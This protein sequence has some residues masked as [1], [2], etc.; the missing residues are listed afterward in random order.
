MLRDPVLGGVQDAVVV[1]VVAKDLVVFHQL[2]EPT[3]LSGP[4]ELR[5]VLDDECARP[6]LAHSPQEMLP[7]LIELSTTNVVPAATE[8]AE[9]LARRPADHDVGE[10]EV[11][12]VLDFTIVHETAEVTLEGPCRGSVVLDRV[13]WL[14]TE[15]GLLEPERQASGTREEIES[16]DGLGGLR[17]HLVSLPH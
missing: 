15:T 3:K 16:S 10:R 14:E 11:L 8:R 17:L 1:L 9:T 6:Y 7:K 5:N 13:R 2:E 4:L 12:N